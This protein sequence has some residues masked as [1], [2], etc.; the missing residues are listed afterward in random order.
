MK[1]VISVIL[2]MVMLLTSSLGSA[3]GTLKL[4]AR[5][6]EIGAEAFSGD[7]SMTVADVPYGTESISSRAFADSALEKIY[8]PRT[9]S[10]IAEDAFE[11]TDALICAPEFSYAQTYAEQHGF[12]WEDCGDHYPVNVV[13]TAA[14]I[15]VW[16]SAFNGKSCFVAVSLVGT[17]HKPPERECFSWGNNNIAHLWCG[18][19]KI[20]CF[21]F[22]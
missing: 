15:L 21:V 5:L 12:E 10:Y 19:G 3:E 22:L 13:D 18:N 16:S 14:D 11:G 4:P 20:D 1:K 2:A 7:S 8:I 17:A 9:V 6:V